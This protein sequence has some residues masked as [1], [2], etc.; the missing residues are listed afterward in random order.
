VFDYLTFA[1]LMG[2]FNANAETFH[3]SRPSRALLGMTALVAVI[4]L[5]VPY[6]PLAN[7]LGFDALSLPLLGAMIAIAGVYFAS[8]EAA[9]RRFYRHFST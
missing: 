8:A 5:A 6:T 3:H 2:L 4:V 1:V 9:K 7:V